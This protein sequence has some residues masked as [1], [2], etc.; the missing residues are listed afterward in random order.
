MSN[1]L[2]KALARQKELERTVT[3]LEKR[4]ADLNQILNEKTYSV[5]MVFQLGEHPIVKSVTI[6]PV[7]VTER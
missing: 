2:D 7:Q 3:E 6:A 1:S 4:I 5:T